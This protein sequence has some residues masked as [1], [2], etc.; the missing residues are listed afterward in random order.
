MGYASKQN[1]LDCDK[2]FVYN[3]AYD[4]EDTL[5][6]VAINQALEQADEEIDSFL[7]HR[8]VLP[9]ET[10]PGLLNK[11]AINIAFCWL[12]DRG[13]QATELIEHH[14][15]GATKVLKDIIENR[16]DLGLPT[17]EAQPEDSITPPW[18][19]WSAY[20]K[21][22]HGG[23]SL[24]RGEGDLLDSITHNST[25]DSAAISSQLIYAGVH[26]EGFSGAVKV[27]VHSRVMTQAFGKAL[28]VPKHVN[29]GVH[30]CFIAPP[31]RKYLGLSRN[32]EQELLTVIGDFWRDRL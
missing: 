18:E 3:T 23:Q 25:S 24:L 31:Q 5:D 17:I 20:T 30:S 11:Q 16:C 9:L 21:T 13:N 12:A 28:K 22:R 26:Q 32:Y 6:D 8:F 27:A 1:L 7:S 14:Y 4:K 15:K 19:A 29:V 10:V 2:S